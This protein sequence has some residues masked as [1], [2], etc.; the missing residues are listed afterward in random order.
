MT[1]ILDQL[2]AIE[3][4]IEDALW[5]LEVHDELEKALAVYLEAEAKLDALGLSSE[6]PACAEGQRVLAYCLMRQ[7]NILRQLKKPG[8]A[9]ALSERELAAARLSGDE[10]ML[11]RGLLSNG[12]NRIVSG[13]VDK[14]LELIGEA[15]Q[16]FSQGD[17]Y[18]HKQGVG[19]CWILEADLANAG[20][21]RKEPAEVIEIAGRV[22][23]VLKPIENWPGVAR[24]Y[25][26]RATAYEKLG[27]H[28]AAS[29]DRQ[30][31]QVYE[32]MTPQGE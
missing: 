13:E 11:A 23:E 25:A 6:D 9:L 8:E 19:W 27:E 12:T 17:S 29:K 16:I 10:I 26:A 5:K 7:G 24:A 18:D 1:D 20:L 14:G 22:L 30:E 28:D 21:T 4:Q 2:K 32:A 15:C 31:A 3:D